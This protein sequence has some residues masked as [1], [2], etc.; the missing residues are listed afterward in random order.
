MAHTNRNLITTS[1]FNAHLRFRPKSAL[2]TYKLEGGSA[3][4]TRTLLPGSILFFDSADNTVKSAANLTGG[5]DINVNTNGVV[6]IDG[7]SPTLKFVGFLWDRQV[8]VP[9]DGDTVFVTVMVDGTFD[10]RDVPVLFGDG[11]TT[12]GGVAADTLA[13]FATNDVQIQL[14]ELGFHMEG[15]HDAF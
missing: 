10:Q 6:G 14:R 2:K 11:T 13:F 15:I 4:E 12:L 7:T 9:A 1:T 5:A 8:T 3:D